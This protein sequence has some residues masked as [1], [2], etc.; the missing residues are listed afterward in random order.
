MSVSPGRRFE[1]LR[2][3][4]FTCRYCGASAPDVKLEVDHVVPQ[5]RGGSDAPW[6]L[7]ASCETCNRGKSATELDKPLVAGPSEEAVRSVR[8]ARD[9]IDYLW[10]GLPQPIDPA[11]RAE[12]ANR[13]IE[14]HLD[15][16]GPFAPSGWSRELM[17]FAQAVDEVCELAS[18]VRRLTKSLY[19][20]HSRSTA[21]YHISGGG[22]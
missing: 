2:R 20:G 21:L 3:D 10:G 18:D 19:L 8:A 17:A 5:S 7:V 14:D 6:N 16:D 1:V 9:V 12:L 15:D 13:F 11:A 22:A 4:N